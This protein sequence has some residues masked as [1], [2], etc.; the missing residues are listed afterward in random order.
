MTDDPLVG[1]HDK[2][3]LATFSNQRVRESGSPLLNFFEVVF[4][5]NSHE[6]ETQVVW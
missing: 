3:K 1:D 2:L 4:F 6:K 5:V